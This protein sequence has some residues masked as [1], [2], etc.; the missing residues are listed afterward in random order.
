MAYEQAFEQY[1]QAFG[2]SPDIL[3]RIAQLESSGN[4]TAINTWDSNAQAGI[5][6]AGLMQ[7]IEPTF[8]T[9]YAAASAARPEMF[10]QLG[11]KDWMNPQQQIATAAH[12]I[13]QGK[14]SHWSTYDRARAGEGVPPTTT[15]TQ[16]INYGQFQPTASPDATPRPGMTPQQALMGMVFAEDPEIGGALATTIAP[17]MRIGKGTGKPSGEPGVD[18]GGYDYTEFPRQEG[19]PVYAWLQRIG[20]EKFGLRNDPGIGQTYGGQH[21]A[22]SLHYDQR[23]VDWGDALNDP[24]VL[25]QA[26]RY[27]GGMPGVSQNIWQQPGHYD[28][29]HVGY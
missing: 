8:D 21:S 16:P 4:P 20:R 26:S 17:K 13:S 18:P 12:A 7:F 9:E 5:P 19:E 1:G 25:A 29:L 15:T 23:A 3:E 28:H 27:F 10:Q 22:G 2:V 24:A 6:S 14:G 11:P